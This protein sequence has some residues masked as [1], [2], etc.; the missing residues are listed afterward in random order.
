M[1]CYGLEMQV[2]QAWQREAMAKVIHL[3]IIFRQRGLSSMAN[4]LASI[5]TVCVVPVIHCMCQAQ[6]PP[7][8]S[9]STL[10]AYLHPGWKITI[11]MHLLQNLVINT[12]SACQT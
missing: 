12:S 7:A 11:A 3:P 2:L 5:D 1:L 10:V 9:L 8:S 4:I 6:L